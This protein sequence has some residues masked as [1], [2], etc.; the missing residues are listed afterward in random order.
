MP[1]TDLLGPEDAAHLLRRAGFGASEKEI[2]AFAQRTR[3]EG[4]AQLLRTKTRR[5]RPPSGTN[6]AEHRAAQR[7]WWLKQLA[8]PKWRLHEKLALFWHGHFPCGWTDVPELGA[9]ARQNEVFREHGLGSFRSLLYE[10]T[11]DGAMLVARAGTSSR[12]SGPN[13]GYARALLEQFALGARDAAGVANFGE[14]DVAALARALT[15]W[16]VDAK[17]HVG[18]VDA[19]EFDD[20]DKTLFAG[21]AAEATG[22]LGVEDGDGV[23]FPPERNVLDLLLAHRD[24]EDRPTAARFLAGR[25]WEWFASPEPPLALVDELADVFVAAGHSVRALVE[26]ILLHEE[27]YAAPAR[28]SNVKTPA[29]LA[30]Q[31][32]FAL[33]AK[34]SWVVLAADLE[35]M[36][37]LLFDPPPLSG[38]PRAEGWL[39]VGAFGERMR[40]A[41]RVAAGR[42]GKV[43]AFNAKRLVK[44]S[45]T[46][47]AQVV[48]DVLAALRL[49]PSALSRQALIDYYEDGAGLE[50][51]QRF[52]TKFRGLFAL[53]LSL[54]EFQIH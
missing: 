5:A 49:A 16:T 48:D 8:S 28:A 51:T 11:R 38:W 45:S 3:A 4:V 26:A 6:D 30:L 32:L 33:R 34:A 22:N 47:S 7:R 50:P 10:M 1:V 20:G 24:S 13:Q 37:L 54:P 46:T 15:G 41:Q 35:R 52:E 9:L 36:G 31:S 40:F 27:F 25:L 53:A 14:A 39:G 12:G 29:D 18:T 19:E 21:N 43:Y 42:S 2:A 23:P 17:T 44:K